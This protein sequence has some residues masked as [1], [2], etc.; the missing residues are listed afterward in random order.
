MIRSAKAILLSLRERVGESQNRFRDKAF[1]DF[2]ERRATREIDEETLLMDCFIRYAQTLAPVPKSDT[3]RLFL[4]EILEKEHGVMEEKKIPL[5]K[6]FEEDLP[7]TTLPDKHLRFVLD[8]ILQYA[9]ASLPSRGGIR[10]VT[11]SSLAPKETENNP[12]PAVNGGR[13]I[14]ILVTLSDQGTGMKEGFTPLE[15]RLAGKMVQR[16]HGVMEFK[17]DEKT[18]KTT[19]LL[20]L[21]VERRRFF[22]DPSVMEPG[23]KEAGI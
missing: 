23:R 8:S 21:P 14:E 20:R 16:N 17:A 15:L 13:G 9:F 5:S 22:N 2:F 7:E 6:D 10:I 3:I 1:G 11:K 19:I 12:R 4:N 18:R